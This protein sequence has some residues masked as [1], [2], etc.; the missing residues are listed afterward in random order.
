MKDEELKR[1]INSKKESILKA[2]NN[3][4]TLE[5]WDGYSSV[6]AY[7]ILDDKVEFLSDI[8]CIKQMLIFGKPFVNCFLDKED[9]DAYKWTYNIIETEVD[10]RLVESF[11]N[12]IDSFIDVKNLAL[13][14]KNYFV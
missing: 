10:N 13:G 9:L 7:N 6:W 1:I 3:R 2:F 8:K 4:L 5:K 11:E 12:Q 14:D